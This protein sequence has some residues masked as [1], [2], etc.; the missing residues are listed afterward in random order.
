[1]R[2][3]S[4][5]YCALP[6]LVSCL[7]G[8]TQNPSIANPFYTQP[9][10]SLAQTPTGTPAQQVAQLEQWRRQAAADA[11]TLRNQMAQLTKQNTALQEQIKNSR[12]HAQLQDQ[13]L[14]SVSK[15]LK[16]TTA[17]LAGTRTQG[18]GTT[19]NMASLDRLNQEKERQ[20]AA[21]RQKVQRLEADLGQSRTELTK[22]KTQLARVESE[23]AAAERSVQN[24]L[25][26]S[27]SRGGATIGAN[28]NLP[29]V[30]LNA[31][32]VAAQRDGDVIRIRLG[33]DQLF[34][35]GTVRALPNARTLIQRVATEVA[36]TYPNQ[37]IGVEGHAAGA[38]QVGGPWRND[39][40]LSSAQAMAVY[41]LLTSQGLFNAS[42]LHIVGHGS[43]HPVYSTATSNGRDANQRVELVVYP[44][45]V[46]GS[47]P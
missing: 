4:P 36:R 8:C 44:E 15:R 27:R 28:T 31:A 38:A 35:P 21:A 10:G 22:F 32:G 13:H 14:A 29:M 24:Q 34:Q 25:A 2:T 19:Q 33:A 6:V 7:A 42:Q 45:R 9:S 47:L 3:V 41:E 1:M 16:D 46:G 40:H 30:N 18:Q 37:R 12:Q 17:E 39:H 5:W 26:A 23:K 20:L 11:S 43:N